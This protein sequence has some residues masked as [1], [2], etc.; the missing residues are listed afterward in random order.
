MY[1]IQHYVKKFVSDLRQ[2]YP[3]KNPPTCRKPLTNFITYWFFA[4]VRFEFSTLVVIGT[5]C[6][7]SMYII[8]ANPTTIR[9]GSHSLNILSSKLTSMMTSHFLYIFT[10]V[11]LMNFLFRQIILIKKKNSTIYNYY[12]FH[13]PSCHP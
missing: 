4:R 12:T 6:I 11:I 13:L 3:K 8:V 1:S 2:E 7:Y 9:S 10:I 5:D